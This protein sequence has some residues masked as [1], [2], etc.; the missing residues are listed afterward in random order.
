MLTGE[1]STPV[2]M[3]GEIYRGTGVSDYNAL[4]NK[5]T[6]N[7]HIIEGDLTSESLGIWQPKNFSTQEQNTGIK[8]VD[9]K[10]I[11]VRVLKTYDTYQSQ[12]AYF[13]VGDINVIKIDGT[14]DINTAHLPAQYFSI[15]TPTQFI[16]TFYEPPS[17]NILCVN[18]GW[19]IS[20]YN[21]IIFYTK[22]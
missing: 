22:N 20:E 10:D 1:L 4:A 12:T 11:Y 2:G 21:I 7:G 15:G 9:N 17:N 3:S 8:W 6:Y 18:Y 5:P 13:N 16:C 19:T 14:V